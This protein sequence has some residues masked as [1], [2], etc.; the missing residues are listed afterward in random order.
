VTWRPLPADRSAADPRPLEASLAKLAADL[1]TP[2]PRLLGQVFGHWEEIV[3]PDVAAHARPLHLRQGT[4]TVGADEPAWA[5]QLQFL[6][7]RLLARLEEVTGTQEIRQVKVRVM[8][9]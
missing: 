2:P 9:P 6:S 4:L 7:G 3:G 5:A 8:R 1:G